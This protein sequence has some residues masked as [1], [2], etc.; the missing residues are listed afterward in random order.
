VCDRLALSYLAHFRPQLL[1]ALLRNATEI[2][3][4][5]ESVVAQECRALVLDAA[6]PSDARQ[7][8]LDHQQ[9]ALWHALIVMQV[10]PVVGALDSELLRWL[11]AISQRQTAA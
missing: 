8:G 10:A 11:G 3:R 1:E 6:E 2:V 5:H 9:T 7:C 4:R